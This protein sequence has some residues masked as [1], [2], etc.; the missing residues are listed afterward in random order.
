MASDN[1]TV[2]KAL[3]DFAYLITL[4]DIGPIVATDIKI[5]IDAAHKREVASLRRS[6]K[7]AED[8]LDKIFHLVFV[9][10]EVAMVA[11]EALAAIREEGG[12]K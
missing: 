8:A 7:V 10:C 4:G 2:A 9:D 11:N 1:E 5:R 12:V 3:D 6:L